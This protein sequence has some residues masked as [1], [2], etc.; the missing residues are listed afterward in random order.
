[1]TSQEPNKSVRW[2][3]A[4]RLA[5]PIVMLILH[6]MF[7]QFLVFT[8]KKFHN[9]VIILLPTELLCQHSYLVPKSIF[10]YFVG[11]QMTKL[12]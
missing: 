3:E 11:I 12:F 7:D 5:M 8:I 10:I 1:M 6:S 4:C 9:V 2:H